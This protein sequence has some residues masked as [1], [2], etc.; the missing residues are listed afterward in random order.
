MD[1]AERIALY[2][3][4]LACAEEKVTEWLASCGGKSGDENVDI[5]LLNSALGAARTIIEIR[6]KLR[7]LRPDDEKRTYPAAASVTD[8]EILELMESSRPSGEDR[9]DEGAVPI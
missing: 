8:Q 4:W 1:Q 6:R 9:D 2:E 3:G 7:D 5:R